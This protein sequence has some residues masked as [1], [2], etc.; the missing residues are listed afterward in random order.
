MWERSLS[1]PYLLPNNTDKHLGLGLCT[2]YCTVRINSLVNLELWSRQSKP[3]LNFMKKCSPCKDYFFLLI[4]ENIF[5][6]IEF[7]RARVLTITIV[8]NAVVITPQSPY[9]RLRGFYDLNKLLIS[10]CFRKSH[11]PNLS[12]KHGLHCHQV[13]LIMSYIRSSLSQ[14]MKNSK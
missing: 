9:L 10:K 13:N 7:A 14:G 3:N 4:H 5:K 8:N 11:F 12:S 6:K 1:F 2:S